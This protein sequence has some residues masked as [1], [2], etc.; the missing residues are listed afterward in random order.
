MTF[1]VLAGQLMH[2]TNTFSVQPADIPAFEKLFCYRG[3][4]EI[5]EHLTGTNCETAGFMAAA[6][7]HGWEL[8][9]TVAAFANPC[10]KVTDEAFET[11]GGLILEGLDAN[12]DVDGVLLALHGAMVTDTYEDA[13]TE[14]LKRARAIVGDET[15]IAVTFDLHANVG[16]EVAELANI[17]CSYKTYPH[18]DMAERGRQA[19]DLLQRAMAGEIRPRTFLARRPLFEGA[20]GGRTDAGPMLDLQAKAR[21]FEAEPGVLNS[22]INA[23][24]HHSD[25]FDVGPTV[26]VT[27][28]GDDPRYQAMAEELMDDIWARRDEVTNQYLTSGQAADVAR[29]HNYNGKPL[30][31]AD[32]AD[33]PGAGAYGDATNLLK[34]MLDEKL[35]DACFGALRD[36]EA[37][38]AL[39][40][41]GPGATVTLAV[42]GKTDAKFGGPPLTLTGAVVHAGDGTYTC[43]GPMWAGMTKSFGPSAVLRV[44]GVDI[45]VVTNLL[46]ITDMQQFLT[47]GID[48]RKKRTVAL[49]SMQH[50]RA[51]YQPI[52]DKVIVC[53][54]GALA[55]PDSSRLT[56]RHIRRPLYPFDDVTL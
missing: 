49:K 39:V 28:D 30:I 11:L 7:A 10:G 55:S 40:E 9:H 33:N 1:R 51:A 18:V 27:G 24:F 2:E 47:N 4:D 54:S 52:A 45:L 17:V 53:D 13:E 42:G 14:L 41:A 8:I 26:L 44:G 31:I 22:S 23:G 20:D 46:Q 38:A 19:G 15:P 16:P 12:P 36:G 6:E 56:F 50:F 48:P 35:E 5:A 21:R 25:I 43:D 37:A 32:Y 34:A 3:A 29:R